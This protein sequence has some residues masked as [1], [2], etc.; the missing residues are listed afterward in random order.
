MS[1]GRQCVVGNLVD[2]AARDV[3]AAEVS[4]A[5]GRIEAIR[6]IDE[7]LSTFLLPGFIDSHVHVESSMLVPTEFARAAVLHGTVASVS[8]PHEIGN[9]LGV[10]GVNYMLENAARSPLKFYFGAP[11]ACLRH[12]S[13]RQAQRSRSK[14]S[15]NCST[16]RGSAISAK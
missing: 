8:D 11:L 12:R 15:S 2:I 16:I 10:S 1:L 7:K 14:K 13:S 4:F 6:P 5:Q 3:F 9:V